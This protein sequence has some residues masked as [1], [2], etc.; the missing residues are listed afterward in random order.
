MAVTDET[1]AAFR[2][3]LSGDTEQWERRTDEL[4]RTPETS[5]SYFALLTAS[6]V[7]AVER[8]LGEGATRD[9]IIAFVADLR[10]R[11]DE[12]AGR[13]DADA[14]ERVIATVFD[15]DVTTGDIPRDQ[16]IGIRIGVTAI[17]IGDEELDAAGLEE[18]LD[19]ARALADEILG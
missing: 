4:V 9:E 6:F 13:L 2:A 3:Y 10:A 15:D 8:R 19:R 7:E 11:E 18:F 14:T 1:V 12:Y 5:R 16:T 17:I